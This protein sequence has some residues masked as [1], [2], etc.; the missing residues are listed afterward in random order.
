MSNARTKYTR[1]KKDP[2][3][4]SSLKIKSKPTTF[5]S[6]GIM[7]HHR[8]VWMLPGLAHGF[9]DPI[10]LRSHT[11][12][13]GMTTTTTTT[14]PMSLYIDGFDR[15]IT[16]AELSVYSGGLAWAA[17]MVEE[18]LAREDVW[19]EPLGTMT[20]GQRRAVGEDAVGFALELAATLDGATLPAGESDTTGRVAVFCDG[21]EPGLPTAADCCS[22]LGLKDRV[23]NENND[24]HD[25]DDDDDKIEVVVRE[26]ATVEPR[27][28]GSM[29][30]IGFCNFPDDADDLNDNDNE[31]HRRILDTTLRMDAG[32][33]DHFEF[34]MS[35]EVVCGPVLYGG[36]H[37][38][39]IVAVLS[40]RVWT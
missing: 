32:L 13:L 12:G 22:A 40:M 2:F 20:T 26:E 39:A 28:W 11:Q 10:Q 35:E 16:A 34:N 1:K 23:T 27:D 17:A 24:D 33:T 36:R 38:T 14:R 18:N 8:L 37:G 30:E 7:I 3:L 5:E 6:D 31:E 19:H 4:L 15:R 25:D 21:R 9:T 29:T